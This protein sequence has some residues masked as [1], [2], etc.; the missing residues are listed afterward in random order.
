MNNGRL[1]LEAGDRWGDELSSVGE[2]D[3]SGREIEDSPG[4]DVPA[5]LEGRAL[6]RRLWGTEEGAEV[7][8][9]S[10]ISG[11]LEVSQGRQLGPLQAVYLYEG[12]ENGHGQP[13]KSLGPPSPEC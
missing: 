1:I 13:R 11:I 5:R 4:P 12:P 2:G 8:S 7:P 3:G 6:L 10:D 9:S